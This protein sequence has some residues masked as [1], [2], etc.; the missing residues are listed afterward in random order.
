[1]IIDMFTVSFQSTVG[2]YRINVNDIRK[3]RI[4]T[5]EYFSNIIVT[6]VDNVIS[7]EIDNGIHSI[8]GTVNDYIGESGIA[9]FCSNSDIRFDI[10]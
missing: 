3:V 10:R 5:N 6:P 8:Y 7:I 1:M 4:T 9:E 2:E